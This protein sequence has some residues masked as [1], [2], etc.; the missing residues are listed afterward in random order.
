MSKHSREPRYIQHTNEQAL[1]PPFFLKDSTCYFFPL[2]S[3]VRHQQAVLDR[4]LNGPAGGALHYRAFFPRV[5][6]Y[7]GRFGSLTSSVPP[8]SLRGSVSYPEVGLWIPAIS[9]Q[10]PGP[11]QLASRLFIFP[12]Y[13]FVDSSIALVSGREVYGFPKEM[14]RIQVPPLDS[15]TEFQLSAIVFDKFSP[16]GVGEER[17]LLQLTKSGGGPFGGIHQIITEVEAAIEGLVRIVFGGPGLTIPEPELLF[18]IASSLLCGV[19]FTFL[20]QF[21]SASEPLRACYQAIIHARTRADFRRL[22]LLGGTYTLDVHSYA[23]HPLVAQLGLD[24]GT[25]SS[26]QG[27]FIQQDFTLEGGIE[28]WRAP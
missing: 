21:R 8:D 2:E 5:F 14:A 19:T 24:T 13:T 22:G 27:F 1:N 25:F 20:K 7:F 28:V 12:L 10:G 18:S 23:S 4:F 6:L 3:S 16:E 11:L 17:Q 26:I 9:V 15:A